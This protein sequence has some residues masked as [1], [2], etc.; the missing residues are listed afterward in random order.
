MTKADR[1]GFTLVELLVVVVLGGFLVL[2]I[3]Q[4]LI[5]N[6][7][8]YAVNNA[9]ILGQQSL[10]AGLD[11]LFGELRE[12]SAGEGDLLAMG[13]DS[14]T[15]RTPRAF[16]LVCATDYTATPPRLTVFRI[17][18]PI[19]S[20]DSVF[21]FADNDE[22]RASDDNWLTKAVQTSDTTATCSGAPGQ[23]LSIPN[24]AITNDTVRVGAGVRAFEVYTYGLYTIDGEPYLGRRPSTASSPDPLVGPLLP[25]RG[26][27]FRYLDSIGS[28]T[29]VDTLVAQIEVVLRYQSDILDSQNRPVRDSI[30]A[31]VYPRN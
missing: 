15:I 11:V 3:Y 21:I 25:G 14:V 12:V 30:V 16:G 13:S 2:S 5:T 24:L 8:T 19:L 17:G 4:V 7:R 9:Q 6:S 1:R 28:V 18:P 27:S 29:S 23:E 31:R 20:G 26:V 22:A 10:R